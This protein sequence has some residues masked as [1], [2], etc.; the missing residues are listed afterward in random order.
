MEADPR[1]VFQ[2]ILSWRGAIGILMEQVNMIKA[3]V[4]N[5]N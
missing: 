5:V 2:Y 4:G 1:H 3:L